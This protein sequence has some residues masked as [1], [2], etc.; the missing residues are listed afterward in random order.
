MNMEHWWNDTDKEKEVLGENVCPTATLS[1]SNP[2]V[3][4]PFSHLTQCCRMKTEIIY[5]NSRKIHELYLSLYETI[6][7]FL[8]T[9]QR[10]VARYA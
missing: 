3:A 9:Q 10:K 1:T 7:R 5:L 2:S 8:T 4:P 6:I